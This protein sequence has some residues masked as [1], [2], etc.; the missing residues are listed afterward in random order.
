MILSFLGGPEIVA[1]SNHLK[2]PIHVYELRVRG[3]FRRWFELTLTT[4]FGSPAFDDTQPLRILYCDGRFPNIKPG[5][6]KKDGDHFLP[7][8]E[9][10]RDLSRSMLGLRGWIPILSINIALL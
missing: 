7:I 6:Q 5:Q 3:F 10:D 1:L 2:V 9:A 4:R 8:F